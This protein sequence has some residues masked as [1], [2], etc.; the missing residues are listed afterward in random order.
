[1]SSI[2]W[3]SSRWKTVACEIN[4]IPTPNQIRFFF[5]QQLLHRESDDKSKTYQLYKLIFHEEQ[6]L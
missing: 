5:L 2:N 1:M 6:P 3:W 4:Q